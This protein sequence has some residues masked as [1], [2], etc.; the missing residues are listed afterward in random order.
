MVVLPRSVHLAEQ[1]L[2]RSHSHKE[3]HRVRVAIAHLGLHA[4]RRQS[5]DQLLEPRNRRR[6]VCR[7]S[8]WPRVT[9]PRQLRTRLREAVADHVVDVHVGLEGLAF[10][11]CTDSARDTSKKVQEGIEFRSEGEKGLW[12]LTISHTN[13]IQEAALCFSPRRH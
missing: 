9:V 3:Q 8:V 1:V 13:K 7:V 12:A 11:H 6:L 5:L 4:H 10:R 2:V